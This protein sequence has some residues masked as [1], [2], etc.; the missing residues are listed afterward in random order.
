M[1]DI[2][3]LRRKINGTYTTDD[4]HPVPK[5][6]PKPA[7]AMVKIGVRNF[8]ARILWSDYDE[9]HPDTFVVLDPRG[10]KRLQVRRSQLTM[11]P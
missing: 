7:F 11:L 2:S 9:R 5:M 8:K 1:S 3:N 10:D 6:R 4:A